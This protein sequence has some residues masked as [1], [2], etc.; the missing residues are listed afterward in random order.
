MLACAE[1]SQPVTLVLCRAPRRYSSGST[2]CIY[3]HYSKLG[4][5]SSRGLSTSSLLWYTPVI[6]TVHNGSTDMVRSATALSISTTPQERKLVQEYAD[7]TGGSPTQ[8]VRQLVFA[9]LPRIV[10]TLR[11]LQAAGIDVSAIPDFDLASLPSS[12]EEIRAFYT[13]HPDSWPSS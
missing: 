9:R 6:T 5:D 3:W 10:T 7:L 13:S 12:D 2:P 1:G 4:Q 11:E 8:L